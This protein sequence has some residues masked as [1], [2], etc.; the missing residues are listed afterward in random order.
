MDHSNTPKL[1]VET[2]FDAINEKQDVI[3]LDVRTALEYARGKIE[4]SI[5][6]PV[7]DI[8]TKI[9]AIFPD[10]NK[11]MY[12]YC[13]SGSRSDLA[14]TILQK[15]GYLKAYSMISGLLMWKSKKYPLVLV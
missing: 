12:V 10:K 9:S 3:I 15:L 14:V 5:N 7:D 2:V 1:G 4:G 6:I 8:E 11:I 13:L